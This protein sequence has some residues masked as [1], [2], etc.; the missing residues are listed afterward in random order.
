MAEYKPA[1]KKPDFDI[2]TK[3]QYKYKRDYEEDWTI[4]RQYITTFDPL[5][6]MLIGVVYDS[7][8]NSVD[9]SKITDSYAATL[10]KERADRVIA[11]LPDG[12][13]ESSGRADVGKAAFMD[14]L[15]QKWI[16]PNA[17]A[18]HSF[19]EKLNMWQLYSS[20][21]GYMPMF[22]DW[23]VSPSGYVGPD[24]W[25]WNPRNLVP[26]QGRASLNDMEYIT[27]L[28]WVSKSYL[29]EVFEQNGGTLEEPEQTASSDESD[30]EDNPIN[31]GGWDLEAL[32]LLIA[33]AGRSTNPDATRDSK[34]VRERTPQSQKRGILLATRYEAGEDGQWC[35]FAP[36]HGNIQVRQLANPHKNGRIPFVIKYSQPLFDSFYGLGDFQ[37]AKP[38]QFARDGLINFYFKGIKMNLIPPLVA[39]ANGVLKHTLDYR[40]GAVML[41][42][43]PNSIRRLETST[44]GLATFQAAQDSLTGSLL[45]LYGSQNASISSGDAL[46]PGQGKTPQAINLYADKE[47]TRDGSE[48]RHLEDAIQIL[49]DGFFS[50]I[51]NVGTEDIPVQLFKADIENIIKS[52]LTDIK[53]LFTDKNF[54]IDKNGI[55]G[56]LTIKP[57]A[58]KGIEYRFKIDPNSTAAA[59]K[60]AMLQ[61]LEDFLGTLGKFQN[62]LTEDPQVTVNWGII[63]DTYEQLTG[64]PNASQFVSFDPSQPTKQQMEAQQAAQPEPASQG[65]IQMPTGQ[66]H[67]LADLGKLYLNTDDWWVKNQILEAL[68][69]QPAPPSV[70]SQIGDPTTNSEQSNQPPTSI[71]TG[72]MFNDPQVAAAAEAIN[73]NQPQPL[74]AQAPQPTPTPAAEPTSISTGHMFQD[75]QIAAAAD[76][77]NKVA[78][79]QPVKPGLPVA[80]QP[81]VNSKK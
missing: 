25:L 65:S 41:E 7:V 21:Y 66:V 71:S 81:V 11:K 1:A 76:A 78:P 57:S 35:T 52:G 19:L 17:N 4:H 24:C 50:L 62:I 10:A 46:N 58:L 44:A 49:T 20:V 31:K 67:E 55:A 77:I 5:E 18:Q 14:I 60:T 73:Q 75:P 23:N 48:R 70:Q 74:P 12:Q 53:D 26:Q 15:R 59:N 45:S 6:A 39:N 3:Y 37:R 33:V 61:A 80:N 8:S 36:D 29:E 47:A 40:E 22:Y 72:H 28:T 56:D 64:I 34:I 42:T 13:T 16:Y 63:M 38:L 68:G 30:D 27:A 54:K 79:A 9:T 2:P 69:F 43:I 51:A 32:K